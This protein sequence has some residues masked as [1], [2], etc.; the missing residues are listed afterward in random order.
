MWTKLT[1]TCSNN[2]KASRLLFFFSFLFLFI[3]FQTLFAHLHM[4]IIEFGGLDIYFLETCP[5]L[6][7]D[8]LFLKY[9]SCILLYFTYNVQ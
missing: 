4:G 3:A 2:Y 5:S 6:N 9:I 7:F 8:I 1:K